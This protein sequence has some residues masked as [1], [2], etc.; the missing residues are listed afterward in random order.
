MPAATV[1]DAQ[2]HFTELFGTKRGANRPEDDFPSAEDG[3]PS[4]VSAKAERRVP[5]AGGCGSLIVPTRPWIPWYCAKCS[6]EEGAKRRAQARE[7]ANRSTPP[8]DASSKVTVKEQ[9]RAQRKR[10]RQMSQRRRKCFFSRPF[11][12]AWVP[13]KDPEDWEDPPHCV[14]CHKMRRKQY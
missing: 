4:A 5:C 12:H 6:D 1:A 8:L 2:D 11:G 7:E 9:R 14:N 10:M 3:A 13:P